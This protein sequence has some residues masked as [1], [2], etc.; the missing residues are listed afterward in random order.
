MTT[1]QRAMLAG[2][3]AIR[4]RLP[5]DPALVHASQGGESMTW[6][7]QHC[8]TENREARSTCYRCK[9][10]RTSREEIAEQHR[11]E[12]RGILKGWRG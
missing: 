5:G 12:L 4:Q 2:A 1:A 9:R 3:E 6:V 8:G 10:L 7:C 11:S